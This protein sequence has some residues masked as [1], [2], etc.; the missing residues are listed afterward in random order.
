MGV[1][2]GLVYASLRPEE[3]ARDVK[4]FVGLAPIAFFKHLPRNTKML[5]Y[6]SFQLI[7]VLFKYF[8]IV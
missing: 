1:T 5:K 8:F 6:I 3:A 7:K 4:L 2:S